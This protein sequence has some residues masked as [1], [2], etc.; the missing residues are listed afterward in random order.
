MPGRCT[1]RSSSVD[2]RSMGISENKCWGGACDDICI[3]FKQST[4]QWLMSWGV[5]KAL[6]HIAQ[7][8]SAQ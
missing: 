5:R 2:L 7:I 6:S 8:Q 4:T 3:L 1:S